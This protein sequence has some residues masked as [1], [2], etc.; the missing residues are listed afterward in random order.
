MDIKN[1]NLAQL[2][3]RALE[4]CEETKSADLERL[5]AIN[6]E[7]EAI[8][9]R[10][11]EII[12]ETE[13]R[14]SAMSAVAAGLGKT[15]EGDS[16]FDDEAEKR[17]KFLGSEEYSE[18]YANYLKTGKEEEIRTALMTTGV[19]GGMIPVPV[20]VDSIIHTAWERNRIL[21]RARQINVKGNYDV[22]FEASG[23]DAVV[24]LEDGE[25]ITE[26]ELLEGIVT[27]VPEYIKKFKSFSKKVYA[28][29]GEEFVRYIYDELAYR[30]F[31]L[32]TATLLAQIAALPG[33]ADSTTPAAAT[34]ESD[35]Q[36]GT[37]AEALAE[38]SDEAE[39]PII[40]MNKKTWGLFKKVQAAG[41]YAYDPFEGYDVEFNASLPSYATAD[42]GEVY[43]IV[44]DFYE[45]A[46]V[47]FP[48]G[49]EV[50]YTFDN[51][52][53]KKENIIEVLGEMLFASGVVSMNAFTLVAKPSESE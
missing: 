10:K 47:N 30:I 3:A 28:M 53:R 40:V 11:A 18:L 32:G 8:K 15:L 52:T 50:E 1:M 33:T 9:T 19:D 25:A 51:L 31:K 44:G 21:N 16:K 34:V 41:N 27:L 49:F 23:S 43:M 4:L 38:L 17:A 46:L 13:K 48:N 35:P 12:E 45:G 5:N 26:Q 39:A 24:H 14:R 7:L 42:P 36:L 20:Y 29:R 22:I 37:V 6:E 2:E